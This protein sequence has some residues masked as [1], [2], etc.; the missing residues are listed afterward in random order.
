MANLSDC[1]HVTSRGYNSPVFNCIK[2]LGQNGP[3]YHHEF[4][5]VTYENKNYHLFSEII[6]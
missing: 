1:R 5:P 2:V 6:N 3:N 4:Y